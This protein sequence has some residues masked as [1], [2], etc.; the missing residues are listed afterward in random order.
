[1]TD[2]LPFILVVDDDPAILDSLRFLFEDEGYRVQTSEKGEYAESLRDENGGLPD[3]IVLDVLLSGKD[4]RTICRKLK[5][6]N[7]TRHIPIVMISAYPDAEHSSK[8]VGADAFVAKP[9]AIDQVLAIV[10]A[11]L[12]SRSSR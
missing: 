1:V 5:S 9:F 3:L 7:V 4:G 2:R 10:E 12:N 6:Q 8:E 11:L